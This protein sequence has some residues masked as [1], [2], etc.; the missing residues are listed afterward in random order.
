MNLLRFILTALF[1]V[2]TSALLLAVGL[3][4]YIAPELPSIEALRDVQL[5]VPLRVYSRDERLIAEFGEKRRIPVAID[6]VPEAMVKAFLAAEDDRF[7]EH[8]GVDYQGLLRA[9][10]ELARTG[11]KRQGGSTI[12]MQVARNFFLTAEKSY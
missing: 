12:T 5:Q 11:E 8:P 6:K 7:F 3:Y 1:G 4:A 10:F 9:G 2:M